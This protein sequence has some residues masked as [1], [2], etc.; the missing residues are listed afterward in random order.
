MVYALSTG[1]MPPGP[2]NRPRVVRP[3]HGHWPRGRSPPFPRRVVNR[4]RLSSSTS[5]DRGMTNMSD[6]CSRSGGSG[7][8]PGR[9]PGNMWRTSRPRRSANTVCNTH[10]RCEEGYQTTNPQYGVSRAQVSNYEPLVRGTPRTPPTKGNSPP[11]SGALQ[12]KT[13]NGSPCRYSGG[14]TDPTRDRPDRGRG[15]G[16]PP[17]RR[18]HPA[19]ARKDTGR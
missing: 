8:D 13:N 17:T 10:S 18:S 16:K 9:T 4:L 2:R 1:T 15:G 19:P 7:M 12:A 3:G 14:A 5:S 11:C 6:S